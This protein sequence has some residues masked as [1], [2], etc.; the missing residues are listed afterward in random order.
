MIYSLSS[1]LDLAEFKTQCAYLEKKGVKV[2]LKQ[3]RESRTIPQNRYLHLIFGWF[4]LE[5]GY[6][7]DEV[8]Q[9]IFKRLVCRSTFETVKNG[10][11]VYRSTKDLNTLEMTNCIEQFRDYSAKE[12]KYLPAPNEVDMLQMIEAHLSK[13]GNA[14]YL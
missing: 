14:Q 8:K 12:G 10:R 5:F 4:G 11:T 2:E 9:D 7:V 13:Y 6:S 3:K 1:P